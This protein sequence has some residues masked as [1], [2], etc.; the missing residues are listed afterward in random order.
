MSVTSKPEINAITPEQAQT[1]LTGAV[2]ELGPNGEPVPD[3]AAPEKPTASAAPS[4]ADAVAAIPEL[5]EVRR[6]YGEAGVAEV[7]AAAHQQ[8]IA[9]E[10]QK[11][12]AAIPGWSDPETRA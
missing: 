3:D 9:T 5:A 10:H 11:L 7:V 8:H 1:I 2:V 4:V 12:S 6:V